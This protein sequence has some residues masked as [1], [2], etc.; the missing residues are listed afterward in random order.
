MSGIVQG[1]QFVLNLIVE[2]VGWIG[3]L[4]VK[5]F[6]SLWDMVTDAFTWVFD[7]ALGVV[8]SAIAA[9]PLGSIPSLA[10]YWGSLPSEMLNMIGLLGIDY[11]M[12]IIATAL[13]VRLALQLIPFVRLGS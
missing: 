5:V 8:V 12:G 10:D 1:L 9:I 11:G 3:E 7:S 4:F 6:T 13:G 2:S